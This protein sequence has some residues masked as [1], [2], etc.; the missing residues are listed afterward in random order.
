MKKNIVWLASY[1]K[2]GNTWCRVFLS[3]YLNKTNE[4]IDINNLKIGAIF[5]S[6]QIIEDYTGFDTSEY[7]ANECDELRNYAFN[8]WSESFEEI[9]FLK[10]HDAYTLLDS[11]ENMFP[12][13]ATKAAIYFIRNPLDVT[14]SFANHMACS[15]EKAIAR[16]CDKKFCIAASTKKY[17]QQVRQKLL[18]WNLHL[19]SWTEQKDFPVLIIRYEDMLINPHKEFKKILKFLDIKIENKKFNISIQNSC[20]EKMKESEKENGFKEKPS[21]CKN[22]FNIGKSGYYKEVLSESQI[23]KIIKE[24]KYSMKKFNYLSK[25]NKLIE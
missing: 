16:I 17:N 19:K 3:N 25:S 11:G 7:T 23:Q 15:I 20:F 13:G 10:S 9:A 21:V 12:V 14:I 1:P 5:S 4:K 18:S 6:R 2:S 22:F 24:Q 8:K